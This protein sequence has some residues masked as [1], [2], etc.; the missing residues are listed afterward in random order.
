MTT[1]NTTPRTTPSD[2]ERR[3][4]ARFARRVRK[5]TGRSPLTTGSFMVL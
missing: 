5:I 2:D 1:T 3:I 4:L